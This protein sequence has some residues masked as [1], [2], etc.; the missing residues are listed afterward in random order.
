MARGWQH[1]LS[2]R[3]LRRTA[4]SSEPRIL[5]AH[6]AALFEFLK[7]EDGRWVVRETHY[8]DNKVV[9]D[10]LSGPLLHIHWLQT[11][12]FQVEQGVIGIMKNEKEVVATKDDGIVE[13]PAG[14]R[15][16]F[17]AH[18]SGNEDLIFKVWA[19]PQGLDHSFDENFLRNFVGYQHDCQKENLTPSVFQLMLM[20]YNSSTIATPPFW[21]PI[22]ILKSVHYV[23]AVWVGAG[24][25]GYEASYP[26]YNST[27]EGQSRNA[28]KLI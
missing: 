6:D 10:G 7:D 4:T 17:W 28:K 12:Y 9:R 24:L 3:P 13:I 16:R 14:T 1:W 23:L 11:E 20:S 18:A 25:L 26:E 27:D 2:P 15:H 8:I 22:W 21:M 5:A 19:E